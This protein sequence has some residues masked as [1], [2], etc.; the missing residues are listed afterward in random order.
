MRASQVGRRSSRPSSRPSSRIAR[1]GRVELHRPPAGATASRGTARGVSRRPSGR[2]GYPRSGETPRRNGTRK[3]ASNPA[4]LAATAPNP[5]RAVPELDPGVRVEFGDEP[6]ILVA[7]GPVWAPEAGAGDADCC[8][9]EDDEG[10]RDERDERDARDGVVALGGDAK[11]AGHR[12]QDASGLRDTAK[13]PPCSRSL[14]PSGRSWMSD[15]GD[16]TRAHDEIGHDERLT[17]SLAT[18]T[19]RGGCGRAAC[20]SPTCPRPVTT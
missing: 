9:R 20:A 6:P 17:R 19:L 3:K 12:G 14:W 16:G 1:V 11:A 10:E 18:G 7:L 15:S 8:A 13:S 2:H 4:A 5:V